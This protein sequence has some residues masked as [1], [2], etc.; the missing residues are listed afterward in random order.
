[1]LSPLKRLLLRSAMVQRL[2]QHN[3]RN[4]PAEVDLE[5][6]LIVGCDYWNIM[7]CRDHLFLGN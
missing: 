2:L 7:G 5:I 1:M 6:P 4:F 3:V